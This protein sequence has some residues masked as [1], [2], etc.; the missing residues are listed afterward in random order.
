MPKNRLTMSEALVGES[1]R[2]VK[3]LQSQNRHTFW[4]LQ[5]GWARPVERETTKGSVTLRRNLWHGSKCSSGPTW[6]LKSLNAN[7][8]KSRPSVFCMEWIQ[9]SASSRHDT[10]IKIKTLRISKTHPSTLMEAVSNCPHIIS[11]LAAN[12]SEEGEFVKK[13]KSVVSWYSHRSNQIHRPPKRRKVRNGF[14]L[15]SY[16]ELIVSLRTDRCTNMWNLWYCTVTPFC[17]LSMLVCRML[18]GRTCCHAFKG[19]GSYILQVT[20]FLL[21]NRWTRRLLWVMNSH[22]C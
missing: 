18:V 5:K 9:F 1:R 2:S 7:A 12:D 6:N 15:L 14:S 11:A 4:Q 19:I 10:T 21:P 22:R 3:S 17:L 13:Y 16:V 8:T 20:P